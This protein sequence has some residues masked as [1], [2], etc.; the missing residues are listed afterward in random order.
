MRKLCNTLYRFP[1]LILNGYC[2]S[3]RGCLSARELGDGSR[4]MRVQCFQSAEPRVCIWA[5]RGRGQFGGLNEFPSAL[6]SLAP[7]SR[8]HP[9][10]RCCCMWNQHISCDCLSRERPR[11]GLSE[12]RLLPLGGGAAWPPS[13]GTDPSQHYGCKANIMRTHTLWIGD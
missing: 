2:I 3:K 13:A 1:N 4:I 8:W 9:M 12:A 10:G 6:Y 11:P 7:A 5:R